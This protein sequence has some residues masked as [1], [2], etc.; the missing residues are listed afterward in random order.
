MTILIQTTHIFL[1]CRKIQ[2]FWDDIHSVL[3]EVLGYEIPRSRLVL[4]LGHMEGSVH[5]GDQYL[6]KILLAVKEGYH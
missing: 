5:V 3:C 4:Y 1:S 6:V 2:H